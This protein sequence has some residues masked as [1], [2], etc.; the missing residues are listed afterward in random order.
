[1]LGK[2]LALQTLNRGPCSASK[3]NCLKR[4]KASH[5]RSERATVVPHVGGGIHSQNRATS[6]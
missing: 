4:G 6:L 3:K 5:L 2:E 1:M